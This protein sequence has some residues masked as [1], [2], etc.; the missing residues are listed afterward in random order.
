M[1]SVWLSN[2]LAKDALNLLNRPYA[3]HDDK[4]QHTGMGSKN[5]VIARK[6]D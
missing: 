4:V 2:S 3:Q 1:F 5:V 6:D